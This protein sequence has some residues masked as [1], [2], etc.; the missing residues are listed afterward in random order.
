[1]LITDYLPQECITTNLAGND[2]QEIIDNLAELIFQKYPE[3][4]KTEALEGIREREKLMTTGIGEGVA[5]PH[6]RIDSSPDI[7]TAFGLLSKEVDF[8]SLDDKPVKLV[9]LILFPKDKV[10]LQLKYLARVSRLLQRTSL[11]DDLFQ[12]QTSEDVLNTIKL[13]EESHVH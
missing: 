11:H 6:A 7:V 12:C 9:V 8:N 4:D 13:F 2:K 3:I 10:S 5:I 1:M